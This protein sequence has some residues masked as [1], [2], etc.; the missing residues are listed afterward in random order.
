MNWD[1]SRLVL[2]KA[3]QLVLCLEM[4][5]WVIS[6]GDTGPGRFMSVLDRPSHGAS[7]GGAPIGWYYIRPLSASLLC[8]ATLPESYTPTTQHPACAWITCH[9]SYIIRF[10]TVSDFRSFYAFDNIQLLLY[11]QEATRRIPIVFSA[12][13]GV[14]G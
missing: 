9:W 7:H 4:S 2:K 8:S 1:D 3:V 13:N 11:H 6:A 14:Q 12:H 5:I 10:I